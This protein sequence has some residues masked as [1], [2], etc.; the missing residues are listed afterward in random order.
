MV[1]IQKHPVRAVLFLIMAFVSQAILFVQLSGLFVAALQIIVYA[2][3]ILI[4][5]LFVIMLLNLRKDEFGQDKHPFQRVLAF[6]FSGVLAIELLLVAYKGAGSPDYASRLPADFASVE[7]IGQLL[8]TR[9]LLPFE[10]TSML[11]MAAIL[12]A[13]VLAKRRLDD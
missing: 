4:L 7:S 5:F 6:G 12:G 10:A 1:I 11:L 2:G 3:A 8:F 13:V 9:Y